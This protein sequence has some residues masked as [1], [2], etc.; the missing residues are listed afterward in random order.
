MKFVN[1][2]SEE[3]FEQ[4][5]AEQALGLLK[6]ER[7][8]GELFIN[9]DEL[10]VIML[11]YDDG[12][13][14]IETANGGRF[15][16]KRTEEKVCEPEQNNL[17]A[18]VGKCKPHSKAKETNTQI[19]IFDKHMNPIVDYVF[20][21]ETSIERAIELLGKVPFGSRIPRTVVHMVRESAERDFLVTALKWVA[22]NNDFLQD[23]C[24]DKLDELVNKKRNGD[25]TL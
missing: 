10:S 14:I 3:V 15:A 12:K 25:L 11:C 8:K 19:V 23:I 6:L 5:T 20:N 18:V 16:V 4:L 1:F 24:F 13:R 7:G 17:I 22:I 21:S 9:H 2:D